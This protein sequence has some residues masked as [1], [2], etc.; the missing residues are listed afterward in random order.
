MPRLLNL[1]GRRFGRLTAFKRVRYIGRQP[2]RVKWSC[3][4]DCGTWCVVSSNV[5][6]KGVTQSCGCLQ[7]ERSSE[8]NKVHK[9]TH[10]HTRS[11]KPSPT[12]MSWRAMIQRCEELGNIAYHLYGGRGIAVC[13]RWRNSFEAFLADMNERPA[14]TTLDRWPNNDGNYEPGNCRWATAKE[15]ATNRRR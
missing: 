15:Q 1:R 11:R 6:M 2:S 14:N 7:R 8:Y 13:E 5:L 10:G 12:Y 4:C 9:A 3:L